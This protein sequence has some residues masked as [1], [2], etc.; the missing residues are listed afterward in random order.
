MSVITK[1]KTKTGPR[2]KRTET[3]SIRMDPETRYIAELAARK[4]R[5]PLSGFVEW[6]VAQSFGEIEM[7]PAGVSAEARPLK[8]DI[9]F[10]WDPREASRFVL[11]GALY[12]DLMTFDEQRLWKVFEAACPL[13]FCGLTTNVRARAV[14]KASMTY[15]AFYKNIVSPVAVSVW[16]DV[17]RILDDELEEGSEE[18]NE[19]VGK[20]SNKFGHLHDIYNPDCKEYV[21][22]SEENL[23]INR[24]K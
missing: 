16:P 10:L 3:V 6:A 21:E 5:R 12:P 11:L 20:V 22:P 18:Y 13:L 17:V 19:I 15:A 7:Q 9:P 24:T 4:M 8:S 14:S 1:S 2:A 23:Q